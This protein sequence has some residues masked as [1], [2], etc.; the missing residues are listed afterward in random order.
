[1][2]QR[3]QTFWQ[4]GGC[5]LCGLLAV[6]Y[7]LPLDGSEF[8]GGRATGPLLILFNSGTLFFVL[9][10]LLTFR[11]RQT[12]A[13]VGL[14]ADLLCLPLYLYFAAPGLFRGVFTGEYSVPLLQNRVGQGGMIWNIGGIL[15]LALL[16]VICLRTVATHTPAPRRPA[17]V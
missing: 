8:S 14:A 13:L 11:Y 7:S 9:A 4:A 3:H 6:H 16:A 15:S 5:L 2:T 1:M 10:L 17:S 12:A